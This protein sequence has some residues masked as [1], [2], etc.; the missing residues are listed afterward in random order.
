MQ[1]SGLGRPNTSVF[2]EPISARGREPRQYAVRMT[3]DLTSLETKFADR[4]WIASVVRTALAGFQAPI[5]AAIVDIVGK[6]G[7]K[8]VGV[9]GAIVCGAPPDSASVDAMREV[10]TTAGY[11]VAVRELRECTD[12][13]CT[14]T[15]MVD[16]AQAQVVPAGWYSALICGKH[17]YTACS[18]CASVYIMSCTNAAG[19]APS[20]RCDVCGAIM[21]EWGG[22]KLWNAELI[23]RSDKPR[24]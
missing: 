22:T 10:L 6:T 18:S 17:G 1:P 19:Q 5:S 11:N 4:A 23:S 2:I 8:P 16:R 3:I 7:S 9:E 24:S 13:A 12:L 21:I 20:V 15:A 14:T